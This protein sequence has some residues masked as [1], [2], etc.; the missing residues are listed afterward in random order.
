MHGEASLPETQPD[1]FCLR[2]NTETHL[3]R[4]GSLLAWMLKCHGCVGCAVDTP[5]F[6][7]PQRPRRHTPD[8]RPEEGPALMEMLSEEHLPVLI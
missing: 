4:T 5:L 3:S 8:M 2:Q 7:S 1:G 6:S